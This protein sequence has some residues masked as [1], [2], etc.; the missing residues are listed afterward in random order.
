MEEIR[1]V[2]VSWSEWWKDFQDREH[3]QLGQMLLRNNSK[4]KDRLFWVFQE[5]ASDDLRAVFVEKGG[6]I[7]LKGCR[8]SKQ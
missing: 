6:S 3:V 7:A 2:I 8:E 4:D 1:R 5:E